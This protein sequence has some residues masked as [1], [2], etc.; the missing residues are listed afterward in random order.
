MALACK[1]ANGTGPLVFIDYVT[2]HSS[3][4]N[5]KVY[6]AMI[7]APIQSNAAKMIG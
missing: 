1:A 4:M 5:S 2:A 3:R 6:R 7:S